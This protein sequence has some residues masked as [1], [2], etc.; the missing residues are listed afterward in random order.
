VGSQ[1]RASCGERRVLKWAG[2]PVVA[3]PCGRPASANPCAPA[4]RANSRVACR[5]ATGSVAVKALAQLRDRLSRVTSA[6]PGRRPG[7]L[8]RAYR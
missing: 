2:P 1:V 3:N 8:G 4:D 7:V 5:A 6:G